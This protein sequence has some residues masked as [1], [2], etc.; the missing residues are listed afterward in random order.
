MICKKC[1]MELN[2][3]AKFCTGCGFPTEEPEEEK[4]AP[5][6][7]HMAAAIITTVLLG[8]WI[9]GIPAIVFAKE[10][11]TAALNGQDE[12]ARRFSRRAMNFMCIGSAL[13]VALITFIIFITVMTRMV[14]M[15]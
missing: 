12:I 11:E 10:C 8:N 15:P 1:G 9:L 6:K 3:D 4:K 5:P 14:I 13:S 2:D 7:S